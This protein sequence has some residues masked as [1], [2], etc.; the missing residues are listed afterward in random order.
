MLATA[1]QPCIHRQC[2]PCILIRDGS[3]QDNKIGSGK[4]EGKE[5]G[6]L[7]ICGNYGD[8]ALMGV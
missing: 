6:W 4:E 1:V 7:S 5:E 3:V 8:L 2:S